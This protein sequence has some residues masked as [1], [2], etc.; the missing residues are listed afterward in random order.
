[1]QLER[2][3][4]STLPKRLL[5]GKPSIRITYS[6]AIAFNKMC[7]ESIGLSEKVRVEVIRNKEVPNEWFLMVSEDE[8]AFSLRLNKQGTTLIF[9]NAALAQMMIKSIVPADISLTNMTMRVG[10]SPVDNDL[11]KLYPI[12]TNSY[13][14]FL[15]N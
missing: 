14:E 12:L 2:F 1:M 7:R 13:K 5:K 3:N 4:K 9:Q 10:I 11:G 8:N 6:G 15:K